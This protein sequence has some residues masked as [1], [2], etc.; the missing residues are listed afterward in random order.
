MTAVNIS[1]PV[2]PKLFIPLLGRLYAS[3]NDIGDLTFRVLVGGLF[4]PHGYGK[5]FVSTEKFFDFFDKLGF[6]GVPMTYFI[7]SLEFFGGIAIVIGLL[8]RPLAFMLFVDMA[9]AALMVHLPQGW[10]K[11]EY[12]VTLAVISLVLAIRGGGRYSAD[13]ALFG[14]EF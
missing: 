4:I 1:Q 5:L 10:S 13:R 12:V 8:T 11:S 2:P 6:P 3:L 9:V 14:R 7:G